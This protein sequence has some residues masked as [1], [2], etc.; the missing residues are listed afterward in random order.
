MEFSL[1]ITLCITII[2]IKTGIERDKLGNML[3]GSYT[4]RFDKSG[5]IKIPEKFRTAIET[6]YGKELFIT[7]LTDEAVQIYPLPEWQKLA[8]ISNVGLLQFKPK[9]RKFLLRVNRTGTHYEIDSKGRILIN[10]PLR[11]KAR[12]DEEEVTVIGLNNHL[13]VWNTALLNDSI[14]KNPLTEEDFEDISGLSPEDT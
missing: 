2:Y 3:I 14:E 5:R 11:D 7:S 1:D 8:G 13:E 4:A 12:L 9:L 6:Q 10:Q